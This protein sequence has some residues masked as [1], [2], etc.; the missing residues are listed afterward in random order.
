MAPGRIVIT[1]A[2]GRI[3]RLLRA[4]LEQQG[5]DLLLL[6]HAPGDDPAIVA[7]DLSLPEAPWAG[8]LP[9]GDTLVHLAADP[10]S[11]A[12]WASLEPNNLDATLNLLQAAVTRRAR[13]VV[14]ASSVQAVLG[15]VGRAARIGTGGPGAPINFYGATKCV[16]ERLGAHYAR[17]FGLSVIVLRIGWVQAG[18]NRPGPHMGP[19]SDQQLWLGNRDCC[20]GLTSAIRAPDDLRFG[21]FNLVSNNAGMPWDLDAGRRLLGWAPSEHSQPVEPPGTDQAT[22]VAG[23]SA[24]NPARRWLRRLLPWLCRRLQ[25]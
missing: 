6:D 14:L 5:A 21:V 9:T 1:G 2:A 23:T 20:T 8:L 11:Q 22:A 25:T 15:H 24:R 17:H 10:S 7:A 19:V 3:G 4:Y 16:A 18:E 13:R 12:D